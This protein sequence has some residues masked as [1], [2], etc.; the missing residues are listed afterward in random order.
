MLQSEI[1]HPP[2]KIGNPYSQDF[3]A[4]ILDLAGV[5]NFNQDAIREALNNSLRPL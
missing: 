4:H 3:R 5:G 1:R 2:N